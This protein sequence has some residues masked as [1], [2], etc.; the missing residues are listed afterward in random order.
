MM[1]N[2]KD[3]LTAIYVRRSVSDKDK[4]NNS[5]SIDAQKAEC[6]RF[7]GN[8]TNYRIY[9]DDGK[10][11]KDI[12]HRPAFQQMMSDAK[13]GLIGRIVVKKYD[14]F[15]RN[16]REYLNIT[17]ELDN[18]G[19][20]VYSLS[21]PFNTETKEGRMMR[22]NLLNFAEF[23][24]ETIAAR[25]ADAY[26]TKAR[27]TGFYQGGKVYYGYIPERRT[28]NGKTGSVLVPS[29]QAYVIKKSYELYQSDKISLRDLIDYF[30]ESGIDISMPSKRFA[31][32]KTNMDRSHFSRL[33]VS[34]LYVRADAEVYRYLSSKGYEM[35]DDVSAFDGVHGLFRHKNADGSEYIKVGYHEGLVDADVWLAV[36]DKK[37]HNKK[38]PNNG[39]SKNSWLVG[40]VKCGHCGYAFNIVYGWNKAHTIKWRY[41]IDSG[42]YRAN[43]CVKKRLATKTD[44]VEKVVY[45]A[46]KERIEQLEIAKR[47]SNKPN[48][49]LENLK[50]DVLRIDD[51]IRK[52]MDKLANADDI[53][54]D[55]INQRVK[56]F[57]SKKSEIEEK[58]RIQSRKHKTINSKPLETP[59]SRWD[60][61]SVDEKHQL[62]STMIDVVYVSDEKGIDI[63]FSI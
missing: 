34:P 10:S 4:D 58:I 43:G 54:F 41:Y 13:D 37:S 12:E 48:I 15:S 33:L 63:R 44:E 8:D 21:E 45:E 47:E 49:E 19:I 26:N 11:G 27:E 2:I 51:E 6:V 7:V 59:L 40:L 14:R 9:C 16:M 24:R 5:L 61:L 20:G 18:L 57:H 53:L 25:V 60:K 50:A 23:E 39:T 17:N 55:Y 56:E 46:M 29:K 38:I 3:K 36:Q 22:N 62:A 35:L 30:N 52:L 32:G 31:S 1:K 28:I 42:A